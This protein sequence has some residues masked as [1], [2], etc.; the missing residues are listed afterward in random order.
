MQIIIS[1]VGIVSLL[2]FVCFKIKKDFQIITGEA[3]N[4]KKILTPKSQRI[5]N[6]KKELNRSYPSVIYTKTDYGVKTTNAKG[7]LHS[8]DDAPAY[9]SIGSY[10]EWRKEGKLHRENGK[11]AVVCSDGRKGFFLE[12][13]RSK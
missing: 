6:L 11:P 8:Y 2:F 3:L 1:L 13:I 5:K 12:G 4:L 7:F 9:V 10:K